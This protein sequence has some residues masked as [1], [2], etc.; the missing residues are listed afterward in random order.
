M[1]IPVFLILGLIYGRGKNPAEKGRLP[2][3][4]FILGFVGFLLAASFGGIPA[5]IKQL[6]VD[7]SKFCLVTAIAALGMKTNLKILLR[8]SGPAIAMLV[9]ETLLLGVLIL[10]WVI[11][12][13]QF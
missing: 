4:W 3:P 9:I 6:G 12:G 2:L 5:D 7:A 10:A 1:L 11:F 13:G 8:G